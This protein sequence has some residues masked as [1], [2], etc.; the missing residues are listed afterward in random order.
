[1]SREAVTCAPPVLTERARRALATRQEDLDRD[2][3]AL[4]DTP[5]VRGTRADAL[6]DADRF[7]TG[8]EGEAREQLAGELLVIGAAE[9][10]RL[11]AQQPVVVTDLGERELAR[12]RARAA[13]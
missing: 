8:Y 13:R 11:D 1:M 6:D 4:A 10:A 9:A 5:P 7:V 2:A 12:S 3:V